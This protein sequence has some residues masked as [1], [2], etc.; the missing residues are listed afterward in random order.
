MGS[1]VVDVGLVSLDIASENGFVISRRLADGVK[2]GGGLMIPLGNSGETASIS[3]T[4]G[5]T[6]DE[7]GPIRGGAAPGGNLLEEDGDSVGSILCDLAG[8]SP[9]RDRRKDHLN[10]VGA[11]VGG[12]SG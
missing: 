9:G 4:R 7:V 6:G 8:A 10:G 3:G 11:M 2:L 5:A 12:H 1:S